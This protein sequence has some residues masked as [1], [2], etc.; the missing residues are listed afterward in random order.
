MSYT[1][2]IPA[3]NLKSFEKIAD[4]NVYYSKSIEAYKTQ[5]PERDISL[6]EITI[7][8]KIFTQEVLFNQT[9]ECKLN[10]KNCYFTNNIIFYDTTFNA[11]LAIAQSFCDIEIRIQENSTFK[12][13][14]DL[15]EVSV[16]KQMLVV[17][18]NFNLCR[19]TLLDNPR[20]LI[21]GGDFKSLSIGFW[22]GGTIIEE[23]NI[24]SN[25][26]SGYI[27]IMGDKTILK[28]LWIGGNADKVSITIEHISVCLFHIYGF[29]N[30][31]TLRVSNIK[32]I[33][34]ES[35]SQFSIFGSYMGKSD[36]NSIDFSQF[37]E[38]FIKE[39]NFIETSFIN[40]VWPDNIYALTARRIG[41]SD[42][43]KLLE[44][45]IK[46][47]KYKQGFPHFY[48]STLKDNNKI[49]GY[50]SKEREVYRQLKYV[51]GKQGDTINEQLFHS[52][53]MKSYFQSLTFKK[54]F[55]TK[56]VILFSD[57]FGDF[58]RSISRPI[59][60]LLVGHFF[61]F[62]ILINSNH[63]DNFRISLNYPNYDGFK[64]GVENYL[65]LINPLRRFDNN[66]HEYNIIIDLLMRIWSTYMLYNFV[67]ASRRFIK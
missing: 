12:G 28:E 32:A 8:N 60:S 39:S 43:D 27:N 56:A 42:E 2:N 65:F 54:D 4:W 29:R 21:E 47:L 37:A 63:F 10:F 58:G 35:S 7:Q 14:F 50:F 33:K 20:L 64:Y 52:K 19:W 16:K 24:K 66:F 49:R 18:G 40:I 41:I 23:L 53:E 44:G 48:I 15:I 55:W 51:M 25:D 13:E 38:F 6:L 67:R 46:S 36:F 31:K 30:D 34:Q 1:K 9:Y 5:F 26:I 62:L 17:D 3:E 59:F 45:K 57:I 61:L 11:R 22:G